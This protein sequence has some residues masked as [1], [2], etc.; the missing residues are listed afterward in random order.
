MIIL[1]GGIIEDFYYLYY[2]LF[3]KHI[4]FLVGKKDFHILRGKSLIR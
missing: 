2:I 1:D 3:Q 4:V